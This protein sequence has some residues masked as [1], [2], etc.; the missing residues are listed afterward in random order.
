MVQLDIQLLQLQR[1]A[2][3]G[4]MALVNDSYS[5]RFAPITLTAQGPVLLSFPV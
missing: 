1:R 3:G 2:Q 5:D 4:R